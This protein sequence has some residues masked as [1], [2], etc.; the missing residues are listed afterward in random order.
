M[1]CFDLLAHLRYGR[2][3]DQ[4]SN[5]ELFRCP[6]VQARLR[7]GASFFVHVG[8]ARYSCRHSSR[9]HQS[10]QSRHVILPY[11]LLGARVYVGRTSLHFFTR[12][13]SGSSLATPSREPQSLPMPA[14]ICITRLQIDPLISSDRLAAESVLSQ[15]RAV[16][17]CFQPPC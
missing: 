12:G 2:H 15:T 14:S 3:L 5:A 7:A 9:A 8:E 17:V 6:G 4:A 11:Q 10:S 1:Q 16:L 13:Q